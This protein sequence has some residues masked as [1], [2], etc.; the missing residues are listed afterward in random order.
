M[1]SI[2]QQDKSHCYICEMSECGDHLDK[3]HIF[4]GALRGMSEIYGL[5]VYLHHNKCH[6]FGEYSAHQNYYIR[7]K[8]QEIAQIKAMEV[9]GWSENEFRK[10]FDCSYINL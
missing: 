5:T 3:H 2:M 7:V 6:I 1:K 8:L 10:I 9:Y 4:G